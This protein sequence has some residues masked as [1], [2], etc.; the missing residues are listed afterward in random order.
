MG[1]RINP[2]VEKSY[3]IGDHI[4]FY[5]DK[6][7]AW[8]KGIALVRHGKTLYLKYGNFMR[9]V[10][11]DKVRPDIE[12]DTKKADEYI[13][14]DEDEERFKAEETPVNEMID[15][16][17]LAEQNIKL[18]NEMSE[19]KLQIS[20]L[21]KSNLDGSKPVEPA[22]VDVN[23][24]E[25]TSVRPV[26]IDE[27]VKVNDSAQEENNEDEAQNNGKKERKKKLGKKK[28][29][30]NPEVIEIPKVGRDIIFKVKSFTDWIAARVVKTFKKTSK[31]KD[32]RHLKLKMV[33]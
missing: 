10:A 2:N 5:D 30:S 24:P 6:K 21:H 1:Q 18:R 25:V 32:F 15:E 19:L 23:D 8:K 3:D 33:K 14:P 28:E 17:E 9:R 4:Y 11:I 7:K 13:E 29:K 12:G 26:S 31:H 16:L 27:A 22:T 20:V